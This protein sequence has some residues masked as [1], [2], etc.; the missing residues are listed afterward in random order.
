MQALLTAISLWLSTN[1]GLPATDKLP[2]VEYKPPLEIALLRHGEV[3]NDVRQRVI[4]AFNEGDTAGGRQV[5]SVYD[6]RRQIIVLP[7]GW[8]PETPA[9]LSVLVHEMVHHL[10]QLSGARFACPAE[11]EQLAYR[12]QED[13]LHLFGTNLETEFE[14]NALT[15]LVTTNCSM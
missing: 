15:L 5:V 11:R 4:E 1:Y 8:T 2:G 12:A 13:W 3:T 9:D 14:I 10:Q 6:H 7:T